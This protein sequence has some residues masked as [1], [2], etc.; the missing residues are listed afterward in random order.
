MAL[1]CAERTF[2]EA[3]SRVQSSPLDSLALYGLT[4]ENRESVSACQ[5]VSALLPGIPSS[6]GIVGQSAYDQLPASTMH[7]PEA[8]R[9]IFD[10]AKLARLDS[11]LQEL[12]AGG[13]RALIYFQMTKMIDLME[14]YLVFRQYKYLR[15]DG[16]SKIE[17][18]RD[19]VT[20]WQNRYVPQQPLACGMISPSSLAGRICSSSCS[21]HML[22]AWASISPP[23]TPSSSTR[24]TGTLPTIRRQWTAPIVL[25]RPSKSRSTA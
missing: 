2:M 13:H 6:R 8:E 14:E 11:L 16:D 21:A 25:V 18:R 1:R 17:D 7:F 5:R 22:V 15:L 12:K 4:A 23:P 9:L 24:T 3:E 19:M 20:D 10:S